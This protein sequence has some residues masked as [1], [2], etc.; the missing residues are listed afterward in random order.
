MGRLAT[1][2]AVLA[3]VGLCAGAAAAFSFTAKATGPDTATALLRFERFEGALGSSLGA[4]ESVEDRKVLPT[5]VA[6]KVRADQATVARAVRVSTDPGSEVVAITATAP[7]TGG[8]EALASA[9]TDELIKASRRRLLGRAVEARRYVLSLLSGRGPSR[10]LTA[11]R[12]FLTQERQRLDDFIAE[13]RA[14]RNPRIVQRPQT[15][16]A[17]T[18][19]AALLSGLTAALAGLLVALGVA[20]VTG[21]SG[22]SS[23][24]MEGPPPEASDPGPSRER[25]GAMTGRSF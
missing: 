7:D 2:V 12:R 21:R 4:A 24:P 15:R 18:S 3:F 17:P 16:A 22:R 9:Y 20:H 19:R 8:A 11:R 13:V 25:R 23:A 6:R 5:L 10:V 14:R 1:T